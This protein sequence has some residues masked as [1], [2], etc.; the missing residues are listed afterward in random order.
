MAGYRA[1][2]AQYG[3]PYDEALV[4]YTDFGQT[5][6]S[7]VIDELLAQAPDAFLAASDRLAIS[8]LS[9]LKKRNIAIPETVSLIGFTNTPVADLLAPS[10]ST[11]EQP[12]REIGQRAAAQLIDLIEGKHAPKTGTVSIPT[13]LVIRDSSR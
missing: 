3:L 7:S 5:D 8:C 11:V 1:A 2:L 9:T 4:R 12:A 13:R 10:L 6:V